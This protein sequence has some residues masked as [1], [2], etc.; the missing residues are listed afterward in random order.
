M[1]VQSVLPLL[2]LVFFFAPYIPKATRSNSYIT[3]LLFSLG[4]LIWFGSAPIAASPEG[5]LFIPAGAFILSACITN[6]IVFLFYLYK[7]NLIK[8]IVEQYSLRRMYWIILSIL[9]PFLYLFLQFF[10]S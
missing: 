9:T 8:E 7:T 10:V 1:I 4:G 6:F 3:F 5:F 2:A